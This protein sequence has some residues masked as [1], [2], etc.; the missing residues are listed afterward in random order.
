MKIFVFM[1]ISMVTAVSLL[2]I[3]KTNSVFSD[4]E[5]A[6]DNII[7]TAI[8][9]PSPGASPEPTPTGQPK[10]LVINEVFYNVDKDHGFDSVKDRKQDHTVDSFSG[11][12]INQDNETIIDV[13]IES[14]GNTGGNIINGNSEDSNIETGDVNNNTEINIE[15]GD[16][17]ASCDCSCW[18]KRNDEWVELYN[19]T[20]GDIP[21]K[22]W[23]L[24]DNSGKEIVIKSNKSI[25]AGGFALI[26]KS[27]STWRFWQEPKTLKI[28]LGKIIGDGLDN[29]GDHLFLKNPQGEM[30]D[31]VGWGSDIA[32]W[33][34]ALTKVSQ[35]NSDGRVEPGKDTDSI[36]DWMEE[37]PPTPGS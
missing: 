18:L 10:H 32:V 20:D 8:I 11:C 24:V 37:D 4:T 35:G 13:N 17:T 15:G 6:K 12:N 25:K 7:T 30:V 16:N 28:E 3:H 26:S 23:K 5:T 31:G 14:E 22:N 9:T 34:P 36:L 21:L 1:F 27:A 19:P 2:H 33:N 29:G